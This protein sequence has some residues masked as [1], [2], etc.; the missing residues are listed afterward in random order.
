[1]MGRRTI[2]AAFA[3][4]A[5]LAIGAP[6][7]Q[8]AEKAV[9]FGVA[10]EPYPPFTSQ[11]SDGKWVGFEVD[12]MDAVCAAEKLKCVITPTA[13]DGIIPA[14]TAH[15]IDVIWS[16]MSITP[17]REK[18][19]GFTDK[20][21]NTPAQIIGPKSVPM[22]LGLHDYAA[23]KG[24]TLGVQVSTT[25]AQFAKKYLADQNVTVKT[26]DT[27]DNAD[28][29]LA[30]G[31]VD[32]VVADSI[33]LNDFLNSAAGKCCEVK[34]VIPANFDTSV[35]GD[36]VGGGVRKSDNKLRETL[37]AGIKKVRADGTYDKLAKKYFSFDVYGS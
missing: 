22:K 26:Y 18:V 10:A 34:L 23:L 7:G 13:W 31:R 28:A 5:V 16:S 2:L 4:L 14:L 30:A 3:A 20:Y 25:H 15:K 27:Q 37:N 32:A 12:L 19:I 33:A 35:F 8:A 17:E 11:N 21:Y 6:H 36:G 1:M 9:R 24:K 29:D